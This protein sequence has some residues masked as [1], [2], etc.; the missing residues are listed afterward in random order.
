MPYLSK[1]LV[2]VSFL[3][4]NMFTGSVD[5]AFT[6]VFSFKLDVTNSHICSAEKQ[7]SSHGCFIS[8]LSKLNIQ[9]MACLFSNFFGIL[10]LSRSDAEGAETQ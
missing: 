4:R 1:A 5:L 8:V 6:L 7:S 3:L 9:V 2:Y 10:V